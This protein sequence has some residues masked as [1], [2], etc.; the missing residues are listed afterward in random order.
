MAIKI[1]DDSDVIVSRSEYEFY[2]RAYENKY[3]SLRYPTLE[4]YIR[5][6]LKKPRDYPL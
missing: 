3:G 1:I 2:K 6:R 5:E 4:E